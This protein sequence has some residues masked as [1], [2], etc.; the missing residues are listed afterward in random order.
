ML[1]KIMR[2][3]KIVSLKYHLKC[4]FG[5]HQAYLQVLRIYLNQWSLINSMNLCN[6]KN[7]IQSFNLALNENGNS[8]SRQDLCDSGFQDFIII[9]LC[10]GKC[11][12]LII[13]EKF[14]S[15]EYIGHQIKYSHTLLKK[16]LIS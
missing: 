11:F 4:R 15:D 13:K 7:I 16:K 10:L 12:K 2:I 5:G 6:I 9:A 8:F 14:E 1:L 3:V